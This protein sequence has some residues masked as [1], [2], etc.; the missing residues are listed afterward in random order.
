VLASRVIRTQGKQIVRTSKFEESFHQFF[1]L[2]R[3]LKER[4]E[5]FTTQPRNIYHEP[6]AICGEDEAE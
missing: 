2:L 6:E 3:Y 5:K 4:N 1:N